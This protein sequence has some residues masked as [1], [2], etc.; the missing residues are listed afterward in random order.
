MQHEMRVSVSHE[1]YCLIS[2]LHDSTYAS[3]ERP[4]E[5]LFLPS[6]NA[7]FSIPAVNPNSLQ[8]S[9]TF[10]ASAR[11]R[12]FASVICCSSWRPGAH[13]SCC[14]RG[15]VGSSYQVCCLFGMANHRLDGRPLIVDSCI[16]R[17]HL[18]PDYACHDGGLRLRYPDDPR[19]CIIRRQLVAAALTL[20]AHYA[21]IH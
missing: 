10:S 3:Y 13:G 5:F 19:P 9:F 16:T 20:P 4:H 2:Q 1:F 15:R 12:F 8:S 21:T 17:R 7:P 18:G 11:S 6:A 14:H